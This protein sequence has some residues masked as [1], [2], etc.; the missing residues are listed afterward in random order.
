MPFRMA[1]RP[2]DQVG[3]GFKIVTPGYFKALGLRLEAGRFLDDRDTAGSPYVVVVNRSFVKRYS[4]NESAIG[5][6]ILVE[7]ILPIDMALKHP[8]C[9]KGKGACPPEDVGGVWG[10]YG[11]LEAIHDPNHEEHDSYLEWI[12]GEFDPEAFD[13]DAVNKALK[14]L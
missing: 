13:L 14:R 1:E 5:K 11:F 4:P 9:L 2:N 8:V 7:K 3:T 12:G 10:Y 6:R